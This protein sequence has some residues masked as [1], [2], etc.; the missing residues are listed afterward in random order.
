MQIGFITLI[1]LR[2]HLAAGR[3]RALAVTS[4]QRMPVL[5]ELPT[6]AELGVPGFEIDQW[7]GVVTTAKVP[8]AIINK[9]SAGIAA[10][11]KSPDVAQRLA[12]DG[13][14]AVGTSA[15]Q[16]GAHIRAEIG[17][18]RKVLKETGVVIN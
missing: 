12:G 11:V 4:R 15:E 9:L 10:A 13:S 5:P 14:T 8:P 1:S 7:Y 16:F 6:V 2:P 3:A 17:K 18:W